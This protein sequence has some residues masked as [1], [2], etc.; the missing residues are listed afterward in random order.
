M[1]IKD[2]IRQSLLRRP[3]RVVLRRDFADFGS[4]TQLS[5]VLF[6]LQ[7]EGLLKRLGEGVYAK[8]TSLHSATVAVAA[9]G[10]SLALEALA[11]LG[12][13][14]I[15]S[16]E[17]DDEIVA[18][19]ATRSRCNRHLVIDG[20]PVHLK[21]PRT[22][23]YVELPQDV[24]RLPTRQVAHYVHQLAVAHHVTY[25]RSQLEDWAEAVT[26]AAGDDV[27]TDKTDGL[28]IRLKQRSVLNARQFTQLLVNHRRE[29]K[30]V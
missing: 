14:V 15:S 4:A 23:T 11:K 17:T 10:E 30:R 13:S 29:S 19:T 7:A 1:K 20:K 22:A 8:T 2:R 9:G 21:K 12:I 3:D 16:A 27:R 28:L 18:Y 5:H 25:K 26:R 6:E 24:S